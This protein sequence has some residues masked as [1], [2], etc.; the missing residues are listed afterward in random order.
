M[1]F[2]MKE[3][4]MMN[5]TFC[6]LRKQRCFP[7]NWWLIGSIFYMHISFLEHNLLQSVL[8]RAG[9]CF[10]TAFPPAKN[11]HKTKRRQEN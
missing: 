7:E 5:E 10:D 2:D 6:D 8:P 1:A 11:E 3:I 4:R 9:R